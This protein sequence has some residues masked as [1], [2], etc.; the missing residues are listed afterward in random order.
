MH[1]NCNGRA[2]SKEVSLYALMKGNGNFK[3]NHAFLQEID[4]VYTLNGQVFRPNISVMVDGGVC[5]EYLN[6]SR[7]ITATNFYTRNLGLKQY[8]LKDHL[9]NVRVTISD[10]KSRYLL[11]LP[12]FKLQ[13]QTPAIAR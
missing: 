10:I 12:A 8:E 6:V 3:V 5:G 4:Y 1:N 9:G 2:I 11:E 7:D 13:F